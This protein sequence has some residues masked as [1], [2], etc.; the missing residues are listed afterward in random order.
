MATKTKKSERRYWLVK[1]E[2]DVFSF[3]DLMNSPSKTTF[4]DGVRNYQARNFMKDEMRPGDGVLVYHS[5]ANPPSV[6]GV[7]VVVGNGGVDETQF[8]PEDH[9]YDPTA[10]REEPRWFGFDL[11]GVGALERS[12]PLAELREI[13]EL[14]SMLLLRK[15]QRLSVMPVTRDEWRVVLDHGGRADLVDLV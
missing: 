10:K 11:K 3:A 12:I 15:G 1:T 5:N 6:V 14:E 7:G 4:W 13:P 8:D 2:P 9:H